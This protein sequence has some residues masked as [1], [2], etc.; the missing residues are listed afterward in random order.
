MFA[1]AHLGAG[2]LSGMAA[3]HAS[4]ST[5]RKVAT[6]LFLALSSHVILDA[7]PHADYGFIPRRHIMP[8]VL[9]EAMVVFTVAWLILR[10]RVSKGWQLLLAAG[11]FGTAVPDLR[12]GFGFLP[13]DIKFKILFFTYWTHSFF[14]AEPVT[15]W[16]G[17]TTQVTAALVCLGVLFA[18]PRVD[19][20]GAPA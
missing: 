5:T 13:P 15:F 3:S 11:L 8:I 17:M 4:G 2:I 6:A 12:F 7:V 10:R 14:H 16:I 19:R 20:A 9:C 1:T 18:M